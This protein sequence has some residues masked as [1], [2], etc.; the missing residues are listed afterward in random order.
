MN[1]PPAFVVHCSLDTRFGRLGIR[2]A[3]PD[4]ADAYVKY[5]HF[6][7][8]RIKDLLRI[9]RARLGGPDD[10][11]QRFLR[12][13]R[14]P[15]EYQSSVLFT[16]TL[17]EVVMGYANIN[18]YSAHE[19][20]PHI[21]S[22]MHTH[23]EL[24]R[25]ALGRFPRHAQLGRG[26]SFASVMVGLLLETYFKV[27]PIE[28]VSLQTRPTSEGINRALDNYLPVEETHFFHKADG[29]A[30]PGVFHM[31]HVMR[32][33]IAWIVDRVKAIAN[34]THLNIPNC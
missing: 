11:R 12:L 21:H 23:R 25:D 19:N 24:V 22:Y 32:S 30:G 1:A 18:R 31:R 20:F 16:L 33:D 17:N 13:I 2:D 8:D 10:S 3:V 34:G 9:D 28:R 29:L 5:W 7:G 6:S 27:L 15:D 4:D 14:T 26:S